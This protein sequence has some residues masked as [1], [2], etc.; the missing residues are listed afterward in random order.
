MKYK[1]FFMLFFTVATVLSQSHSS[2]FETELNGLKSDL[3]LAKNDTIKAK[4]LARITSTY[5]RINPDSTIFYGNRA[6]AISK[7]IDDKLTEVFVLGYIGD[8]YHSKGNLPKGLEV[9]L[10]GIAINKKLKNSNQFDAGTAYSTMGDIYTD[11]GNYRQALSMYNMLFGTDL[12]P[13]IFLGNAYGHFGRARVYEKMNK[14]DS[15]LYELEQSKI[16]FSKSGGNNFEVQFPNV[17]PL[18]PDWYNLRARVY[19]KQGEPNLALDDL[20]TTLQ[21]TLKTGQSGHTANS[22]NDIANIYADLNVRDSAIYYAKKGFQEANQISYVGGI[23]A[24]SQILAEQFE[25]VNDKEALFYQKQVNQKKDLLYGSDNI[26]LMKDMIS[27]EEIRAENL[28]RAQESYQNKLKLYLLFLGL[29]FL[30]LL[31]ILLY[32]NNLRKQK[33]NKLLQLQKEEIDLQRYKAE[34]ALNNLKSTQAQLIQSEKMASLG[35]LT[36]GI[37]HEIQNPLNFVNNFSEVSSEML[38]E[39]DEELDKGDIKEAKAISD[40]LKQN[41]EKIH[42]HGHRASSIVKG[43]LEHSRSST[44]EKVLTDINALA[45]EYLRLSYHGLRAK[46]KNFNAD[47]ATNLDPTLPKVKVIPQDIGRVLLNLINNAFQ[48]VNGVENPK[49][50]VTTKHTE[51]GIQITVSDNGPGIP[52]AIKDKI[53]QP[54]FTTKPTGSGTGLGLSL[55]YD[56]IK[57][58]GGELTLDSTEGVGTEFTIKI[59][60]A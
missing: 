39:M 4:L 15:A 27:Q 29:A 58:H 57:A 18:T 59:P 11:I 41:L 28:K 48:A 32:R 8:A 56:I 17:L 49:V 34:T 37:A 7:R 5:G 43:M 13:D 12:T 14:L 33:A 10:E 53:F 38:D 9:C 22:Y 20:K 6:I 45:D 26:Q 46:D 24:A 31:A 40:D 30:L 55:A 1:I 36:A 16:N 19:I 50:M 44:G 35:E 54:F 51:N 25:S 2:S 52:E 42:H 60:I 21:M 47:F 23:L 3:L